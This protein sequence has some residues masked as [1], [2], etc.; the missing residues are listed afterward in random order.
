MMVMSDGVVV[1]SDGVVVMS[2]GV[3]V[4]SDGCDSL[5]LLFSLKGFSI[6][7]DFL[8]CHDN[9]FFRQL[10]LLFL[11]TLLTN[12]GGC[13]L[14]VQW[15]WHIHMNYSVSSFCFQSAMEFSWKYSTVNRCV[16][17]LCNIKVLVTMAMHYLS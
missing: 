9:E 16:C 2:D 11:V 3:I 7:M 8:C 1:M 15:V 17:L 13:D 6:L 5:I 10:C 4:M 12:K 14:V